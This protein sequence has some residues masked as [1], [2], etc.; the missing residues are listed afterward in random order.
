L[1]P[2]VSIVDAHHGGGFVVHADEKADYIFGT[3]IIDSH[4]KL[5]TSSFP[6]SETVVTEPG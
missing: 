4:S 5:Q 2:K 6:A 3:G 1:V